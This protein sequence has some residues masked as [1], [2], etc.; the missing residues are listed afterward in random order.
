MD[1]GAK[2]PRFI[3]QFGL[4]T[5]TCWTSSCLVVD[6][7]A[8]VD[9]VLATLLV[10]VAQDHVQLWGFKATNWLG[11]DLGAIRIYL[12]STGSLSDMI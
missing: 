9:L 5:R 7:S 1:L 8:V 2:N 3:L 10:L 6:A 12:P 11:A 4:Q